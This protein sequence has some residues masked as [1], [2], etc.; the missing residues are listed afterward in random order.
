[1]VNFSED[2]WLFSEQLLFMHHGLDLQGHWK[3][4]LVSLTTSKNLSKFYNKC[5]HAN[6]IVQRC[7]LDG[8][9][10]VWLAGQA[11]LP[12]ILFMIS[13]VLSIPAF[14]GYMERMLGGEWQVSGVTEGTSAKWNLSWG[15]RSSSVGFSQQTKNYLVLRGATRSK[16]GKRNEENRE[17]F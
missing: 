7:M 10:K 16:L 2:N 13:H 5:P 9:P 8:R 14:N 12:N 3:G 6:A 11:D 1:M 17:T 15:V 4:R